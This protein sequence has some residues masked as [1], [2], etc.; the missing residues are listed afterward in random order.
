MST[1]HVIS[2]LVAKR[3]ELS[4]LMI[5]LDRQKAAIKTQVNHIDHSLAIFNYCDPPRDIKPVRPKVYRFERRELGR[6]IHRF[7]KGGTN[8]SIALDI[9]GLKAWDASDLAL[10]AKVSDSVKNAKHYQRLKARGLSKP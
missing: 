5:D 4:G 1:T 2:A 9:I 6:L 7:N 10:I 8:T 3:A